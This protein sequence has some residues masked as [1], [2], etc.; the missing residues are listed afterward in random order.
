M[1]ESV[2]SCRACRRNARPTAAGATAQSANPRCSSSTTPTRPSTS[3]AP[4]T[5]STASPHGS[6]TGSRT[7]SSNPTSWC[8]KPCS[9]KGPDA[10][11]EAPA[12]AGRAPSVTPSASFLA[13]TRMAINAGRSQGMQVGNGAD[14]V[15]RHVAEAEGKPVEGLETLQFQ[16]N[17]F[18]HMPPAASPAPATAQGRRAG[19]RAID[20]EPVQ[21]DGGHAIRLEARRPERLRPHARPARADPRP[22]PTG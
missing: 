5:R 21:G 3:S 22:T 19:R 12:A 17:M 11:Q 20:A 1:V 18:N 16:L 4:S 2:R 14:M 7:P 9:P 10:P 6:T 15:L 13:T 8:S